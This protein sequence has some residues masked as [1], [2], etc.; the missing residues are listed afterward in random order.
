MSGCDP[1]VD[2][3]PTVNCGFAT[4]LKYPPFPRLFGRCLL[5]GIVNNSIIEKFSVHGEQEPQ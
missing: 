5:C 2:T 4:P 3:A 1:M